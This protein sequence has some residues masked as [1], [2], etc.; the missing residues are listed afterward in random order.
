MHS[1][2]HG[3]QARVVSVWYRTAGLASRS[4]KDLA[5]EIIE[6]EIRSARHEVWLEAAK[7]MLTGEPVARQL[8]EKGGEDDSPA[9]TGFRLTERASPATP[10]CSASST[11]SRRRT[12]A[13]GQFRALQ[14][15]VKTIHTS[16]TRMHP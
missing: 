7:L 5:V 6:A 12:R 10:V 4:Q 13:V 15:T 3:P 11:P 1:S 16:A 8:R 2:P 14:T 9:W